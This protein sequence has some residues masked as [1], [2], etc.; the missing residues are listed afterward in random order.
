MGLA[1]A[2]QYINANVVGFTTG[3]VRPLVTLCSDSEIVLGWVSGRYR[4]KQIQKI[5]KY[6]SLRYLVKRMS[7]LVRW[8]EG[9]TGDT[10]NER[11]D[12]LAGVERKLAMG[13]Q[14][15][16]RV[17]KSKILKE[18]CKKMAET[19]KYIKLECEDL[20]HRQLFVRDDFIDQTEDALAAYAD[21]IGKLK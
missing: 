1:H 15:K 9:H 19:L 16:K 3:V 18:A 20:K 4:F 6:E 21:A 5:T 17:D 2:L 13:I 8:V 12:Q 11:C 7:V 10:W 14:P